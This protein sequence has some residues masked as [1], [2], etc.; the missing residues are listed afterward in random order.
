MFL[1]EYIHSPEVLHTI[2]DKGVFEIQIKNFV[3][4]WVIEN[5][6]DRL[7][8][9]NI[10]KFL[11]EKFEEF[12]TEFVK[13]SK[14]EPH[15][16]Q[17]IYLMDRVKECY[18]KGSIDLT[19][20][21]DEIKEIIIPIVILL[22]P[23]GSGKSTVGNTIVELMGENNFTHIDGDILDLDE[24]SVFK[25]GEERNDYTLWQV[26]DSIIKGKVPILSHGG[27]G[28]LVSPGKTPTFILTDKLKKVF[29][30]IKIHYIIGFP[31]NRVD[32]L[33]D[34]NKINEYLKKENDNIDIYYNKKINILKVLEQRK[35]VNREYS[36]TAD[37]AEKINSANSNYAKTIL[38]S[39]LKDDD[40][41]YKTFLYFNIDCDYESLS[42]TDSYVEY[43]TI[44][45]KLIIPGGLKP[46]FKQRRILCKYD[47]PY[48]N[49]EF[50]HVTLDIDFREASIEVNNDK[51]EYLTKINQEMDYICVITNAYK[52]IIDEIKLLLLKLTEDEI[53]SLKTIL[54]KEVVEFVKKEYLENI[55][56][57][58]VDIK[59]TT[60]NK[61]PVLPLLKEMTDI[62]NNKKESPFF[63][64][65]KVPKG[66]I[67]EKDS[68]Y[69]ISVNSG[70]FPPFKSN[71]LLKNIDEGKKDFT[72]E[73]KF[74]SVQYYNDNSSC[75]VNVD[76]LRVFYI[77]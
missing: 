66:I 32:V 36:L 67:K 75:P 58:S 13:Y 34:P 73:D 15:E 47:T 72:I 23:I 26:Y 2:P 63:E 57:I 44:L 21:N 20:P 1:R 43:K 3:N 45:D 69:H 65:I 48:S 11:L 29:G 28:V 42:S 53:T 64:V 62:L 54:S 74:K 76:F 5:D 30:P 60:K 24:S 50:G 9:T 18:D 19:K 71:E 4:K 16:A 33:D 22:G 31:Y 17:H 25:L 52:K 49:N 10:L 14:I 7:K 70:P 77:C 27:G 6:D 51:D 41:I 37:K 68:I 56:T 12:T 39:V 46:K 8:W 55:K 35:K 38:D 59:K 61:S 40:D